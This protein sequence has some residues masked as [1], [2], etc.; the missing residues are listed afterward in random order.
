MAGAA[1]N[2]L[3]GAVDVGDVPAVDFLG[4]GEHEAR[5]CL[6]RLGVVGIVEA[7]AAVGANVR[8]VGGMAGAALSTEIGLPFFHQLVDLLA[9][10]ILGKHFEVCGRGVR[11][12]VMVFVFGGRGR[13]R[14]LRSLCGGGGSEHGRQEQGREG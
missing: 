8:G 4:H 9:G 2:G 10:H 12:V 6:F 11:V 13:G 7:G 1:G 3:A 5:G 14:C